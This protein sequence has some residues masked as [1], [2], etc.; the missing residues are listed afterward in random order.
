M[1]AAVCKLLTGAPQGDFCLFLLF[2]GFSQR[3]YWSDLPF[4]P[5][6]KGWQGF[7]GGSDGK[8]SACI[9][10]DMGWIPGLGRFLPREGK[11]YPFQYSGLEYSMGL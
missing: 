2:M 1:A 9:A 5:P 8:E 3:E 6:V 4:L 7:P 10:G 11:G